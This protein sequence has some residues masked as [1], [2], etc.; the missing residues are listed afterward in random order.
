MG[1]VVYVSAHA[2]A[3]SFGHISEA[4]NAWADVGDGT[5]EYSP[6]RLIVAER[7]GDLFIISWLERETPRLLFRS[8]DLRDVGDFLAIFGSQD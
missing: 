6:G 2:L 4:I 3:H 5:C 1:D 7:A 8:F